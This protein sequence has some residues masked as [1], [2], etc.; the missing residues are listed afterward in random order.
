MGESAILSWC[1]KNPFAMH[2]Y[3]K[4]T[5]W[6]SACQVIKLLPLKSA[7]PPNHLLFLGSALRERIPVF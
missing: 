2:L 5:L 4:P 1:E 6:F 3:T 7:L